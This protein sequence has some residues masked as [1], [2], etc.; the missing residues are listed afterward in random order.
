MIRLLIFDIDGVLTDG[1]II[2]DTD[3]HEQKKINL[4]DIDAI[5]ELKRRGFLLGAITGESS[6]IVSYFKKRFPWDYFCAGEK[7]KKQ[8][9]LE[10]SQNAGISLEEI[11]Y[12]GDGKYDINPLES[13]GLGI[14]PADAIEDAKRSAD[15]I[16]QTE[17][18]AGELWELVGLL[19]KYNRPEVREHY[20]LERLEEHRDIF[21]KLASD[22]ELM[23][24]VMD[25]ADRI[26]GIFETD[27]CVFL[28]GNGGSAA[29]AQHIATEFVSRFY[30]ERPA[31]NAEALSVNTST[32]TAVGNDYS[33]ERVF[34]RQLEAKAKRG[35]IVIGI[36]TSGRS[37]NILEAFHYAKENGICTVLLTGD[38]ELHEYA[39]DI[40]YMVKIPS[41]ITPRV[42]EAH[43]FIGHLIAEYVEYKKYGEV[44]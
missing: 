33:F 1:T 5:F 27:G 2:V 8:K 36:S 21:K 6:A 39:Q 42:Q 37:K 22:T 35:D 20:F 44:K 4:K 17:G 12:I 14:C 7:N 15:I 29:D 26:V 32:L 43:I 24:T 18:G 38:H 41:K 10:I 11:C 30:K 23:K 25:I 9:I 3:G 31:M 28:C 16:L 34:A 19:D 40:D 13:V